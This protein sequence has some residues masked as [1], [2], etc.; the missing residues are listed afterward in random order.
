MGEFSR[1]LQDLSGLRIDY[2]YISKSVE[3]CRS[4]I[5]VAKRL[6]I[7]APGTTHL[8]FYNDNEMVSPNTFYS[9]KCNSRQ[10]LTLV[11]WLNSIFGVLQLLQFR[12]ETEG[13]YC[14]LLKEDLAS[15]IVPDIRTPP[16]EIARLFRRYR[17]EIVQ[18]LSVQFKENAVRAELDKAWMKWL[19][20]SSTSLENDL[21]TIYNATFKELQAIS[22]A[23]KKRKEDPHQ[24]KLNTT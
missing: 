8:A 24:T 6:N 21:A 11:A 14:D 22:V 4:Y 13:G 15:F 17:S 7:V 10:A 20:W 1:S 12:K 23:G 5:L 16:A 2:N 19:G 9:I 18:P 3:K